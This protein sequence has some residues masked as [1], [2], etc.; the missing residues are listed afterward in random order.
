MKLMSDKRLVEAAAAV[1]ISG[2]ADTPD[3]D[4]KIVDLGQALS[5]HK[6]ARDAA[7]D[8]LVG[9]LYLLDRRIAKG[10]IDDEEIVAAREALNISSQ[11]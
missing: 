6:S 10:V 7:T 5:E 11:Y 4:E 1:T 2:Y 8:S 3:L 9:L